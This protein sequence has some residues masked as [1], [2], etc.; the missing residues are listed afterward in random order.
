MLVNLVYGSTDIDIN[1]AYKRHQKKQN[2][3]IKTFMSE[4]INN[5]WGLISR[6]R[7]MNADMT[8]KHIH[9]CLVFPY[10]PL[11]T[12]NEYWLSTFHNLPSPHEE[13]LQLYDEF[14]LLLKNKCHTNNIHVTSAH[15]VKSNTNHRNSSSS[16]SSRSSSTSTNIESGGRSNKNLDMNAIMS[17]LGGGSNSSGERKTASINSS[18]SSMTNKGRTGMGMDAIMSILGSSGKS[19]ND[20]TSSTTTAAATTTTTATTTTSIS[21][22]TTSK[23]TTKTKTTTMNHNTESTLP[24]DCSSVIHFLNVKGE[25]TLTCGSNPNKYHRTDGVNHHPDYIQTQTLVANHVRGMDVSCLF[26]SSLLFINTS[27][28]LFPPPLSLNYTGM[29]GFGLDPKPPLKEMYEHKERDL[30]V[31]TEIIPEKDYY[32]GSGTSG[33]S[34]V[35]RKKS[36]HGYKKKKRKK[37]TKSTGGDVNKNPNNQ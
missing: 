7:Q 1:L 16:G 35:G 18:N 3:N 8:D 14:I 33:H 13:R 30:H 26:F 17:I 4:M 15:S 32:R 21:T 5:F 10:V 19:K 31:H 6:I 20:G 9:I 34:T 23:T 11:P 12:T 2:I 36:A 29:I 24:Q 27:S 28:H 37:K 22:T 25:Y